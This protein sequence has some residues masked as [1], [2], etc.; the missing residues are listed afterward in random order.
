MEY[1]LE[2]G[3]L[4]PKRGI[5]AASSALA[6]ALVGCTELRTFMRKKPHGAVHKQKIIV[7]MPTKIPT[8]PTTTN[9]N[10]TLFLAMVGEEPGHDATGATDIATGSSIWQD[11]HIFPDP[12]HRASESGYAPHVLQEA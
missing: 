2:V 10:E 6:S 1:D 8:D 12:L 9:A 7:Q 4:K 3:T 11:L 5:S